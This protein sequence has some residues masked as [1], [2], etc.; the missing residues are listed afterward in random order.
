MGMIDA[1]AYALDDVIEVSSSS[2]PD[3]ANEKKERG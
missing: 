2:G 1:A 3:V